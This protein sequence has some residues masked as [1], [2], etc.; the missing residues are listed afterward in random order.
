MTTPH[1]IRWNWTLTDL[2]HLA[3]TAAAAAPSG[4]LDGLTRYQTAW[5]AIAEALVTA[6]TPPARA[7]LIRAGRQAINAEIT[8]C[9]HARGYRNSHAHRGPASSPRYMQYWTVRGDENAID[10]LIDHLAA[11]QI[12]DLFT[13]AQGLAVEALARHDDH[14]TAADALGVGY[15]TFSTR[16]SAARRTFRAAWYAPDT[17]PPVTGHDKRRGNTSPRTRCREGHELSGDNLR[18]QIRK[19]GKTE[20]CCRTCESARDLGRRCAA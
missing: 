2:D 15:K 16:L 1:P 6:E 5:S 11:A 19:G 7:D 9:L 14:Q 18:I 20:R 13:A 8:A 10:R 17:A 12:G 3:K 4:G